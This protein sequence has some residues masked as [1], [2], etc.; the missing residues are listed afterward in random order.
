MNLEWIAEDMKNTLGHVSK[1]TIDGKTVLS[2][3]HA[4]TSKDYE[5]VNQVKRTNELKDSNLVVNGEILGYST[6]K[7]VGV[8]SKTTDDLF[9]R[10]SGKV[11]KDKPNIVYTRIPESHTI[12][13]ILIP[14]NKVS[15]LQTSGLVGIQ[16]DSGASVIIPPLQTGI[17]SKDV[18]KDVYER[19]KIEIQTSKYTKDVAGYIPTTRQLGIV[20]DM[21]QA[22]VKDDVRFFITDFSGSAMNRALIRTVVSAIR[23][24][25]GI[26]KSIL[27][28]P[29]KQY[30]LHVLDISSSKKTT[31][32]ISPIMD[33]LTHSYGV[34]STS[35]VLWGGGKLEKDK[36]RYY[37]M[38]S[39]GAYRIGKLP[40]N[41]KIRH[42]I[43]DGS[44]YEV[45]QKLRAD[46]LIEYKK[47][48]NEISDTMSSSKTDY[49][50][51]LTTKT[52]ATKDVENAFMDVKEI[53]A[54]SK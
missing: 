19:T 31:Q 12:D 28:Q 26:K 11:V 18:F 46:K 33:I 51:R 8:D 52:A 37:N 54:N 43:L 22:Y 6:F 14:V 9:K 7:G 41:I 13:D 21:I 40:E 30:Y 10:L 1:M 36:L 15:E 50:S 35:G 34:D 25:L 20:T 4:M 42:D 45:Y 2:P 17:S 29:D 5:I 53:L 44:A 39:Y 48:C 27:E 32:A 49:G 47:E 24:C 16:I 38:G 23:K 3:H